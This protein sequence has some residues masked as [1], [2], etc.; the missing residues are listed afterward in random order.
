MSRPCA[1]IV[2]IIL[3]AVVTACAPAARPTV[4]PAPTAAP[5]TPTSLPPVAQATASPVTVAP[6]ST[7]APTAAPLAPTASSAA[8]TVG[9]TVVPPA[10]TPSKRA[11]SMKIRL[12]LETT[13]LTATMI[14]SKT[15]QDFV[16]LLPL[17]LTLEDY[18]GTEKI[19]NLPRRLSTEGAPSGSDPSAGDIAYYAPW[20][21]LALFY[22]DFGYSSGLV[23]LGKIDRG[24]EAVSVPGSLSV[25]IE[26]V[27]E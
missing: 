5:A 14:D 22:R 11:G 13:A 2:V 18:A 17:A 9:P 12:R 27:S 25:T 24:M 10:D 1:Q 23:I 4:P 19:S 26:L 8:P 3:A 6:S 7:A 21:N 20:G 16:S 15:T